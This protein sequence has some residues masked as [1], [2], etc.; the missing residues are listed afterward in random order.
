MNYS[1]NLRRIAIGKRIIALACI[2]ALFGMVIG[3][4]SGYA[5]KTHTTARDRV[6]EQAHINEQSD[7]HVIV[8]EACD[9]I[10]I[11]VERRDANE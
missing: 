9:D 4:I 3:G 1:K 10:W 5:M 8:Y 6:K 11:I 7:V 2:T